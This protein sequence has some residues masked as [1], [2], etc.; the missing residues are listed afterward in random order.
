MGERDEHISK[1]V[2]RQGTKHDRVAELINYGR[3][4]LGADYDV[5]KGRPWA[6]LQL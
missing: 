6:L 3:G 5:A 2:E 1:I 4:L